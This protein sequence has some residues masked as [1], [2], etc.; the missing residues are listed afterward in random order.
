MRRR[1]CG[2]PSPYMGGRVRRYGGMANLAGR[3]R[4]MALV[5]SGMRRM[6][7]RGWMDTLK[8]LAKSAYST[9]KQIVN[10]NPFIK[11]GLKDVAK[12][13]VEYGTRKL[14][15]KYGAP[16][17]EAPEVAPRTKA[18]VKGVAV[19]QKGKVMKPMP[20]KVTAAPKKKGKMAP[21]GPP[22][23]AAKKV[24]SK[25]AAPKVKSKA[26]VSAPVTSFYKAGGIMRG[27]IP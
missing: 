6:Y 18:K 13:G 11:Q 21:P 25:A 4:N 2:I 17:A 15:E 3:T 23:K 22:T 14:A 12:V 7:G 1:G 9:G 20:E 24:P 5:A 8:G 16:Q 19:K 10:D 27:P 26:M